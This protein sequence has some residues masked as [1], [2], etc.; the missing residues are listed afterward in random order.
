MTP[1]AKPAVPMRRLRRVASIA[2][3]KSNSD[4][5]Y[6]S[7]GLEEPCVDGQLA[8]PM[9]KLVTRGPSLRVMP[10]APEAAPAERQDRPMPARFGIQRLSGWLRQVGAMPAPRP[11]R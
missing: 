5:C 10:R 2:E 6:V 8:R 3:F 1:A 11:S 7:V 4:M 9:K